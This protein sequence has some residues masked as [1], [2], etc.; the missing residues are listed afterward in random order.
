MMIFSKD[1][2]IAR[3]ILARIASYSTSLVD[4]GK[5]NRIGYSILS[6]IGDL[7]CKKKLALVYRE[8]PSTLRIHQSALPKSASCWGISA[9]KYGNIYPFTAKR[10]LY[11]TLTLLSSI[12]HQAILPDKLGSCMVLRRGRLVSMTIG[13]AWK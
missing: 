11:W 10:G 13:C 3:S 6:L 8:A 1:T 12:A 5:S 4:G 7:S 2:K 9:K